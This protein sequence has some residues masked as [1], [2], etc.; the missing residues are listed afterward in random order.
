MIR[1]INIY[2]W[3]SARAPNR[4]R[5]S[6]LGGTHTDGLTKAIPIAPHDNRTIFGAQQAPPR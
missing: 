3:P 4:A 1:L 6:G 2:L 5:L